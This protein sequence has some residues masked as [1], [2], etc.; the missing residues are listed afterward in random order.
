MANR[1]VK[2]DSVK[3]W[4]ASLL[5]AALLSCVGGCAATSSDLPAQGTTSRSALHAANLVTV[6]D[7]EG[8]GAKHADNVLR[9]V[10]LVPADTPVHGPVEDDSKDIGLAYRQSPR[11]GSKVPRGSTVSFRWWWEAS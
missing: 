6:P 7:I 4:L 3:F 11:P 10:G 1:N 2:L 8:L 9:G 5:G